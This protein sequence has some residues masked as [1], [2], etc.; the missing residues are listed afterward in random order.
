M[1][2]TTQRNTSA[3]GLKAGEQ[4]LEQGDLAQANEIFQ[5]VLKASPGNP[6]A[7]H[8]LALVA[9]HHGQGE[10]AVRLLREAVRRQRRFPRAWSNLGAILLKQKAYADAQQA[11]ERALRQSPDHAQALVNLGTVHLEQDDL[12]AALYCFEKARKAGS[13]SATLHNNL[14]NLYCK[15]LDWE[16]AA[17]AYRRALNKDPQD[18]EAKHNLGQVLIKAGSFAEAER[19]YREAL[20]QQPD[21]V[22][23]LTGLA[24][25][26]RFSP[27]DPDLRLFPAVARQ[28]KSWDRETRVQFFFAWGKALDQAGQPAD[29]FR[30]LEQ[31][32]RLRAEERR[33]DVA[34][35]HRITR[36]VIAGFPASRT[37][38]LRQPECEAPVP[39]F[40]VGMPRS[41]TT[42]VE[43]MLAAHPEVQ[44]GGELAALGD[45]IREVAGED[46]DDYVRWLRELGPD[47]LRRLRS[48]YLARRPQ[49]ESNARLLTDK[50][51]GNA[52]HIG[53]IRLAFPNAA[54]LHCVRN[55][56]D[57]GLSC[58]QTNFSEG[59]GYSFDLRWFG[60]RFRDYA[61]LLEYWRSA[62]PD[63]WLDVPYSALVEDPETWTRRIVEYTS[64]PWDERCLRSHEVE[65]L[66]HT[67]SV[68]QVRQPVYRS[69]VG[70]WQRYAEQLE[71]M[72]RALGDAVD[73]HERFPSIAAH[74]ELTATG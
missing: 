52:L 7:L 74:D 30:C 13:D 49:A 65:R 32:N 58:Y 53:L 73:W 18:R 46:A 39:V 71:P 6:K 42:L 40:V 43:Q 3:S 26:K 15:R 23:H 44:A 54:I 5:A 45:A 31:G 10:L 68:W 25:A 22:R 19:N 38:E 14:G 1:T 8:G 21:E 60:E 24:A 64:L 41:G 66:V 55:P 37:E 62:F 29:A 48:S 16:G 47:D 56:L 59:H 9:Y 20:L 36:E 11:L 72:R 70:R 4:A 2:A 12:T 51:P 57:I 34:R 35:S 27:D 33:F 69:S 17:A 67:A 28:V 61:H 50:M 63:Q